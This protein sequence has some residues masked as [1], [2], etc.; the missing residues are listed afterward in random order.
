MTGTVTHA[1]TSLD[2]EVDVSLVEAIVEGILAALALNDLS[3]VDTTGVADG[4][5]IVYDLA[6]TSWKPQAPSSGG[7]LLPVDTQTAEDTVSIT[8]AAVNPAF[9]ESAGA[10]IMNGSTYDADNADSA[11]SIGANASDNRAGSVS[12]FGNVEN[13]TANA[14][15]E[16]SAIHTD[17]V[18]TLRARSTSD[19][20][21]AYS[22]IELVSNGQNT[23]PAEAVIRLDSDGTDTLFTLSSTAADFVFDLPSAT[24]DI[25][26]A[27]APNQ[28]RKLSV[29][30]NGDVL[31]LVG[32][33]PAWV[34]STG[35]SGTLA[36]LSDVDATDTTDGNILVYDSGTNTFILQPPTGGGST[37]LA[38]LTDVN[39]ADLT[40][41]NILVYDSGTNTY[42]LQPPSFS[43][44][45]ALD[46]LTDVDTTGVADGDVLTYD[47]GTSS[48]VPTVPTGGGDGILARNKLIA[49]FTVAADTSYV[50]VGYLDLNG[51]DLTINGNVAIL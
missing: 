32:G 44:V 48:W 46:D 9:P 21:Q 14:G 35:G 24:G 11:F 39:D 43:T 7:G 41:G 13:I 6:T 23:A 30:D 18:A 2:N 45:A 16:T 51:F 37:T 38:S 31:T 10:Y 22:T 3:D 5:I 47:S 25:L 17:S 42:V 19:A 20:T 12:T 15:Y 36:G 4:D 50:V 28:I 33:I 40:D 34:A 8:S 27:T 1:A 29:E 49:D 26:V